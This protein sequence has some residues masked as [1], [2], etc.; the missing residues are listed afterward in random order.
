M[1]KLTQRVRKKIYLLLYFRVTINK[2]QSKAKES[3]THPLQRSYYHSQLTKRK[4]ENNR[5][6]QTTRTRTFSSASLLRNGGPTDA[7]LYPQV[8][9][10]L[11]KT[12]LNNIFHAVLASLECGICRSFMFFF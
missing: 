12:V 8:Q 9:K 5:W 2:K 1:K 3:T 6:I 4:M 11:L 7:C 10:F